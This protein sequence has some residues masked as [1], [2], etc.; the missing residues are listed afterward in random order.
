MESKKTHE[1]KVRRVAPKFFCYCAEHQKK[2]GR[3]IFSVEL[4]FVQR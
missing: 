3:G 1:F 2:L 4:C